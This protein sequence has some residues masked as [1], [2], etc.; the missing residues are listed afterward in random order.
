MIQN[1]L[2]AKLL[3]KI[4]FYSALET[5]PK[6]PWVAFNIEMKEKTRNAE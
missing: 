2:M 4:S 5:I 3:K 6:H 1:L